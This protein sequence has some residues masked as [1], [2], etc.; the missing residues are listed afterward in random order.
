MRKL[1][2]FLRSWLGIDENTKDIEYENKKINKA[3]DQSKNNEG[4]IQGL[5]KQVT[6]IDNK[7]K[8][9]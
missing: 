4:L 5:Q 1:R 8:K 3:L 7:I 9:H 6:Q 2:G